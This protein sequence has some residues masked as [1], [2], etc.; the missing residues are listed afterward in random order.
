[1]TKIA[2]LTLILT[3]PLWLIGCSKGSEETKKEQLASVYSFK[4]EGKTNIT[5]TSHTSTVEEGKSVNIGFKTGG[6]IKRL[7]AEEGKYVK[8]GQ[9]IGYL[10]DTDYKLSLQQLETQYSQVSSEIK[11]IEEMYRHKSISEND[12]EKAKAG[13]EQLKIQL[14]LTKN[15]LAYTRLTAPISGHIVERFMEEGEMVG[16]GTPVFKIVDNSGV[17]AVVALSANSYSQKDHI[18]KCIGRSSIL[19]D[20]EIPLDIIGFIPDGDNNSLF[21]LRLRI[22]D[23]YRN[24]LLPGMNLNVEIVYNTEA[25]ET[26]HKIPSRALFEHNGKSY[27]WAIGRADSTLTAHEVDIIGA[28]EGKF[29]FVTGLSEEDE[30]VAVGVHHLTEKQKVKVIGNIDN[31]KGKDC[32]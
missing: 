27:V 31:L 13:L 4:P 22:P 12:Y 1:M 10:D 16:A 28:P 19:G 6:E 7:T 23:T 24:Q 30:I 11:R 32:L 17:E 2:Y 26:T 3:L 21:K 15:Q 29:S 5:S 9:V 25:K 8:K 20:K 18:I 14:D